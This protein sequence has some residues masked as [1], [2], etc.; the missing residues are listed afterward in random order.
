VELF[1]RS[2]PPLPATKYVVASSIFLEPEGAQGVVI[3][4][5]ANNRWPEQQAIYGRASERCL[6]M[7]EYKRSCWE[8]V[9]AKT[10]DTSFDMLAIHFI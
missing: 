7:T 3:F 5:C 4:T 9:C 6:T 8:S 1:L 10:M 2:R